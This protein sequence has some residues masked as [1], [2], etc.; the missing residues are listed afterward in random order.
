MKALIKPLLF[1]LSLG[2]ATGILAQ[3]EKEKT[4]EKKDGDVI[5]RKKGDSKEKMTIVIDGDKVTIN[6]KPVEDYKN[7]DIEILHDRDMFMPPMAMAGTL[8]PGAGFNI[9]NDDFMREIRSNKAFL[10]VM[11]KKVADG[12]LITEITKESAAEKAGLKEDD[13][14]TKVNDDKIA[15]ADD[16]YKAIGKYKPEDKVSITYKRGGKENKVDVKLGENKQVKVFSWNNGDGNMNHN[17]KFDMAPRVQGLG[18]GFSGRWD[19]KPRL[20]L[21]VQETEDS[22]GVKVLDVDE[23]EP[24]GKAGIEQDDIITTING[25]AISSLETLKDAMKEVKDGDTLK[26]DILR[27]GKS[28]TINVKFPKELKTTDL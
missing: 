18:D 22:K 4:T 8:A 5:I 16:L 11:T 2:I 24:A 17:F 13:V 10:G 7:D 6:G 1:S 27:D 20:G 3:D 23:D 14:I 26:F 12:A 9:M 28:Q 25:K 15:D 21:Q 19:R